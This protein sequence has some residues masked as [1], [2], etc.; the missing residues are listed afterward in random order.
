VFFLELTKRK[1]L[2]DE[3]KKE[4]F[5]VGIAEVFYYGAFPLLWLA[6]VKNIV[7]TSNMPSPPAFYHFMNEEYLKKIKEKKDIPGKTTI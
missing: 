6:N 2:I 4:Q 7:A 5:D 3:L 1:H